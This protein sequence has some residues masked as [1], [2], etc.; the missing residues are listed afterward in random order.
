MG[1]TK[2]VLC[3]VT[4]A[5]SH[6]GP[7]HLLPSTAPTYL[8]YGKEGRGAS[9][10]QSYKVTP[11]MVRLVCTPA[12]P[13]NVWADCFLRFPC[14]LS[15]AWK[16][17][18]HVNSVSP[19]RPGRFRV[20]K[21]G[22]MQATEAGPALSVLTV[23][24]RRFENLFRMLKKSSLTLRFELWLFF[25]KEKEDLKKKT[26]VATLCQPR[27]GIKDTLANSFHYRRNF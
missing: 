3:T 2:C 16:H 23:S 15:G 26:F 13:G 18:P 19:G 10:V 12:F 1:S 14:S 5:Q 24:R 27:L 6:L 8:L 20:K 17:L 7:T 11:S 4:A 22:L 9:R 25:S 21:E